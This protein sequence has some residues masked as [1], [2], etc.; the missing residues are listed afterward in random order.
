M[1]FSQSVKN[2]SKAGPNVPGHTTSAPQVGFELATNG[3]QFSVIANLD[4]TS[5]YA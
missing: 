5:S 1:I 4:K 3:I 2:E